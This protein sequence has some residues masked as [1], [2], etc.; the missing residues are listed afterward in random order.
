MEIWNF[1][2]YYRKLI[3]S[4]VYLFIYVGLAHTQQYQDAYI[5]GNPGVN[6]SV[7]KVLKHEGATYL[8]GTYDDVLTVDGFSIEHNGL[9]DIFLIKL[10]DGAAEWVFF[11]GSAASDL[12]VDMEINANGELVIGGSFWLEANFGEVKLNSGGSS[13]ALF[14]MTLNTDGRVLRQQVIDGSA[15]KKMA[16]LVLIENEVFVSGSF[17]GRIFSGSIEA[18]ANA[19]I[20]VFVLKLNTSVGIEW[21]QNYG[22]EGKHELMD[23]S[24]D[25]FNEQF[26]VSGH[27][28]KKIAVALDTIQTN[29]FDEDVFIA[30]LNLDGSGKWLRKAGG[31]FEDFN[32]AHTIDDDGNVYITGDYRG[33]INLDDGSQ[34]NT[35]GIMNTDTYLI[36]FDATGNNIWART[37]GSTDGIEI[38]TDLVFYDGLLH[39]VGYYDRSFSIDNTSFIAALGTYNGMLAIFDL[40]GKLQNGTSVIGSILT[41]PNGLLPEADGI[42][43]FG[44]FS[45]EIQLDRSYDS[46][47][48]FYGFQVLLNDFLSSSSVVIAPTTTVCPNPTDGIFSIHFKERVNQVFFYNAKGALVHMSSEKGLSHRIDLSYLPVGIY[49]WRSESGEIG[50]VI[51]AF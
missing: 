33:I 7:Q 25:N 12:A 36:K 11:G 8:Y 49:F 45:G 44:D 19:D 24:W 30:A 46:N 34:I 39:M 20:D 1:K 18:T 38:G 14:V 10:V 28:M 15:T 40:D 23:F 29:S 16:G 4:I 51:K 35:G 9:L 22:I 21:I 2:Q 43:I 32:S 6:T 17:G 27:F 26:I 37:L 41:V 50:K 5:V 48:D 13:K 42:N 47:G 31:Q 3:C